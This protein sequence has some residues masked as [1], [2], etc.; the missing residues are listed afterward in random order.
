MRTT[1]DLDQ[2]VLKQAKLVAQQTG[3]TLTSLVEDALRERLSRR[4]APPESRGAAFKLHTF[5]GNGVRPGVD[6][7]DSGALRDLMDGLA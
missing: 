1:L 2:H 3:T 5:T 6:L 4:T 7:D